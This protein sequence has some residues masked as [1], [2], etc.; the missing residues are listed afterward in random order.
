[1][2]PKRTLGPRTP[3]LGALGLAIECSRK[4]AKLSQE[5][6]AAKA[7]IH[8]THMSGLER[9]ARNP[10]Y[11]TLLKVAA[12]LNMRVG[13]LTTLADRIYDRLPGSKKAS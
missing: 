8:P 1:V 2:P 5:D 11:T 13:Q 9:G 12:S 3:Q 4:K 6:L 10:T 7:E